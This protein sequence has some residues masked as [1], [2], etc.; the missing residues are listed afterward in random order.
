MKRHIYIAL[1]IFSAFI[2]F[3]SSSQHPTN[4]NG[5][6]T[7]APLDGVCLECHTNQNNNLSGSFEIRGIPERAIIGESYHINIMI[8]NPDEDA[9][10]AGFQVVAL[11]AD[12][13]N[14]GDFQTEG[15]NILLKVAK[16][17]DYIGHSPSVAFDEDRIVT[18]SALW[19]PST[20]DSGKITFYGAGMIG[21]GSEG[22]KRDRAIFRQWETVIA[23]PEEAVD[24][25]LELK[26]PISC[27][28]FNDAGVSLITY[29]GI[30]PLDFLWDNGQDSLDLENLA[31]GTYSVTVTDSVG[32]TDSD[33]ILIENP[34][35]LVIQDIETEN[36]NNESGRDGK[37]TL[38]IEGGSP[39]YAIQWVSLP[40]EET[41]GDSIAL[42][43]I[44]PGNYQ[45]IITDGNSCRLESDIIEVFFNTSLS[46]DMTISVKIF[47][48]PSSGV[49]HIKGD[50]R[51]LSYRLIDLNGIV[52][53]E[54]AIDSIASIN[55]SIVPQGMYL[56]ALWHQN[57]EVAV[58]KVV[59]R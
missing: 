31:P 53:M 7:G 25:Q 16:S 14:A 8:T 1:I 18:W 58:R 11:G 32:N 23:T 27:S 10:R 13:T 26:N 30:P 57:D 24:I 51:Y 45:A 38:Q 6:Y 44:P 37:I 40:S 48:N 5:G 20:S 43:S 9:V 2:F 59:V 35:P 29:G 33:S 4:P 15:E 34:A 19:T 17:R 21:S 47:P 52:L 50:S 46:E 56:L 22:N 42:D 28:G 49:I 39:P 54:G 3:A 36:A 55:V 12:L 41:V